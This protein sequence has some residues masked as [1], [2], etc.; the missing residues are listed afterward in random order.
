MDRL[1]LI[2]G[3]AG[4][5]DEIWQREPLAGGLF[6]LHNPGTRGLPAIPFPG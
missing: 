6:E 4:Y 5:T 2:T 1:F 3:S